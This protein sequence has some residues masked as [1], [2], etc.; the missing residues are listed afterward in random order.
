MRKIF[1]TV[2]AVMIMLCQTALAATPSPQW[3]KDLPAARNSEQMIVVAG[4]KGTTA[5]ISMHERNVNGE[6]EQ[7]M[8][9]PGFI[10]RTVSLKSRKTTEKRP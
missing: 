3:V 9:T 7:I 4:V 5:W 1:L 6:W 2:V 8:T 10:G